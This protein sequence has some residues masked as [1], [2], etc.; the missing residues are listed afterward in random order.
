MPRCNDLE[1]IA[2]PPT[3]PAEDRYVA[4]RDAAIEKISAIYDAGNHDEA[5]RKAEEA[6]SAD[7]GAQMRAILNE[8]AREGFG[9]AKLHIDTFYK[10]DELQ[11]RRRFRHARRTA[12][13]C[14]TREEW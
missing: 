3:K 10:G 2:A 1:R 5:A 14:H 12:L 13:R 11:G 9:L 7:L 6:A 8:N 4:A